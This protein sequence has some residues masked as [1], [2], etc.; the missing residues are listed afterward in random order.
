MYSVAK[1]YLQL[2]C[3]YTITMLKTIHIHEIFIHNHDYFPKKGSFLSKIF[4]K[5]LNFDSISKMN[6]IKTC[7][8]EEKWIFFIDQNKT[9]TQ[10]L[11]N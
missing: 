5:N 1:L 3:N 6:F 9:K 10:R 7:F 2:S 8:L 4:K 11:S